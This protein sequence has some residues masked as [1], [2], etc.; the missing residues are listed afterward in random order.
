VGQVLIP[1]TAGAVKTVKKMYDTIAGFDQHVSFDCK[2]TVYR[3]ASSCNVISARCK[4]I[5]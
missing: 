2:G 4:R 3:G 5:N 1:V